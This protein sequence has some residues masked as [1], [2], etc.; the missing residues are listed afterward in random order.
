MQ[1]ASLY[2]THMGEG[3][4]PP[5]HCT[6]KRGHANQPTTNR[7]G[8]VNKESEQTQSKAGHNTTQYNKWHSMKRHSMAIRRLPPSL[9]PP[10]IAL[11]ATCLSGRRVGCVGR[12]GTAAPPLPDPG[13]AADPAICRG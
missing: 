5:L 2:T 10:P 1:R 7:M 6:N 4:L 8:R 11:Q 3:L 9:S 13:M 12:P